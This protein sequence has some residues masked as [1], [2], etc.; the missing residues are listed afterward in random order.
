[1]HTP[2]QEH[3][4][5]S[6]SVWGLP[7]IPWELVSL[8]QTQL[9]SA[10]VLMAQRQPSSNGYRGQWIN[11]PAFPFSE[12]CSMGFLSRTLA[13]AQSSLTP[14]KLASLPS[15]SHSP[16]FLTSALWDHLPN[17]IPDPHLIL[18]SA[19][20]G[21]QTEAVHMYQGKSETLR[22][23][24]FILFKLD[25]DN[26]SWQWAKIKA[27]WSPYQT[28]LVTLSS[29]IGSWWHLPVWTLLCIGD[30][31]LLPSSHQAWNELPSSKTV[32]HAASSPTPAS[33]SG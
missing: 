16:F 32:A 22:N 18:E 8:L 24:F 23:I 9:G 30:F 5:L 14:A 29:V 20:R 11:A 19:F 13:D 10:S 12:V 4:S 6:F 7:P 1:M 27:T 31:A 26:L 33:K 2:T 17:K 28:S 21:T 25:S 15:L 3:V